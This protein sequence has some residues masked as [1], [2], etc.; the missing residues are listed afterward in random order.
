LVP[1]RAAYDGDAGRDGQPEATSEKAGSAVVKKTNDQANAANAE[2]GIEREIRTIRLKYAEAREVSSIGTGVFRSVAASEGSVPPAWFSDV[3]TNTLIVTASKDQLPAIEALI[4]QLDVPK[5]P[6]FAAGRQYTTHLQLAIFET[7]VRR[8]QIVDLDAAK[9]VAN[10]G[11][12]RSLRDALG[13]FGTTMIRYRVDQTVELESKAKLTVGANIPFVRSTTLSKSGQT[14]AQVEYEN[15]GCVV[16]LFGSWDQQEPTRGHATIAL[17]MARLSDST[18]AI[19]EDVV[20]PVFR[21]TEQ[22]FDGPVTAGKPIILLT[23]DASDSGETAM[24]HV[25]WILLQ[26]TR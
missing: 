7:R 24:A 10:A 23:I 2:R 26:R 21:Q 8:D 3:R 12:C 11:T 9:L 4:A 20:A 17:E 18:I 14:T 19:G 6:S 16:E 5:P 1:V 13:E 25:I 15:T 22:R